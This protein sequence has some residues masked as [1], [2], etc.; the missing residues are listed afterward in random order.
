MYGYIAEHGLPTIAE[1]YTDAIVE[2]CEGLATFAHRGTRRDD[3]R[4][5]L[6]VTNY[7]RRAVIAFEVDESSETVAILGV[8]YGGRD[9]ESALGDDDKDWTAYEPAC[10][11]K[12]PVAPIARPSGSNS[13]PGLRMRCGSL[14]AFAAASIRLNRAGDSLS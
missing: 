8:Y 11:A 5:G 3:I 9:Y 12:M 10:F 2:Y 7:K 6:R 14:C 13:T 4:P 1:R